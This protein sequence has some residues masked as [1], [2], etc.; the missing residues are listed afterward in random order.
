M[1]Q[2]FP[3][4]ALS[5]R[6]EA[7]N[8]R[9]VALVLFG[10]FAFFIPRAQ[11]E[12]FRFKLGDQ[13]RRALVVNAAPTGPKRPFV[14]VLH[15]GRGNA[16]DMQRR[17][18]FS[19]LARRESFG[20]AYAEGT[21]WGRNTHAWNTGHLMRGQVG[22]ADDIGYFDTL[23]DNLVKR[24]GADPQRIYMT[25]GSNGAMMTFVYAVQ[26]PEKLAAIAPVVG[27]MFSF[28][29]RPRVPLPIMMINGAAD[30]EVPVQGGMSRNRQ[31]RAGQA[32]PYK[33]LTETVDFWV[34]AN[35][36]QRP[37]QSQITGSCTTHTYNALPGGA[38]TISIVDSVGGHG[39]PG[40]SS[41]RAENTPISA[42]N[43]AEKVWSFLR[44]QRR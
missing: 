1:F 28:E 11:A 18:G 43:G 20:V 19:D 36:S 15:G 24:Y 3:W 38:V 9:C 10:L 14:I 13:Q 8:L 44:T 23:I 6:A 22:S 32:T 2:F 31:V 33:P 5:R 37:P 7:I 27:A 12:E 30:E 39:W 4:F 41:R 25:G 21:A 26:R 40:T 17:T 34:N 16:E 42:F 29:Q 35:R